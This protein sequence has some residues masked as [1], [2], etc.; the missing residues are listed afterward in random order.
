M[1]GSGQT[2]KPDSLLQVAR[3]EKGIKKAEAYY[4]IIFYT[5]RIDPDQ[6]MGYINEYAAYAEKERDPIV[7][8]YDQ[9]HHGLYQSAIGSADSAINFL[10][11][12]KRIANKNNNL[13][14]IRIQ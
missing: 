2:A 8:A 10:E 6:A 4:G 3:N 14:Q 7:K 12:A 5:L 1:A 11:E 9:L 13:L